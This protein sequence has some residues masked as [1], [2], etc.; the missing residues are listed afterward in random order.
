MLEFQL[1]TRLSTKAELP[2]ERI[3]DRESAAFVCSALARMVGRDWQSDDIQPCGR[4]AL[5]KKMYVIEYRMFGH[6]H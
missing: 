5:I 2:F 3:D 6:A 4:W 1:S